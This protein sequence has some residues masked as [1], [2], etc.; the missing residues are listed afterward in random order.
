M[1][2]PRMRPNSAAP[3]PAG[4]SGLA[5]RL[6]GRLGLVERRHP[7]RG[8]AVAI[9]PQHLETE[10]VEGECLPGLRDDARFVNDEP[11]Y[12]GRLF[13]RQMPVHDAV[14]IADRHPAIDVDRAVRLAAH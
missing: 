8:D 5:V 7:Q 1:G 6:R 9:L 3:L 11:G 4:R 12:R 10:T 14:E 2:A 13:V